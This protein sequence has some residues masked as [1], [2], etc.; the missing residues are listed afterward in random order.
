MTSF[1]ISRVPFSPESL[2]TWAGLDGRNTNWPVVYVLDGAAA[3]NTPK[4]NIRLRDVYVGESLNAAARMRQHLASAGKSHLTSARFIVDGKF[5][6]SVCLDL[7]SHLIRLLAGDGAFQVLNRNDGIVDADYYD[8]GDYRQTFQEVFDQLRRDGLFTRDIAEIENSDLFKLSPF[9]ALTHDQ[10]VAVVDIL[11]GLF[12]DLKSGETSTIVIQGEPGTGKTVVAIYILKLLADIADALPSEAPDRD[13]LFADFFMDGFKELLVDT[14]I[15]LVIPQQ[16]LRDSVRKVFQRTPGLRPEMV[17]TA[18]DVG[19][20]TEKFDLL[21][22]DEAHRLNQR[23]NQPSG[24]QNKNFRLITE[25]LFGFDDKTKTQLDWIRAQSKNQIFLLDTAQ[26]VRPADVSPEALDGLVTTSRETERYYPLTTQMRVQAGSDYVGYI[27]RVL[28]SVEGDFEPTKFEGYDLRMFDSVLEM[29]EEIHRRDSE[30]GLSRLVAGYAWPWKSK[31][32]KS[33]FDIDVQ[34]QHFR[35]NSVQTD[36]IASPNSLHEVGSI[37]TVQGYDLNFAGVIIGAD[38]RYDA[39]EGRLLIDRA[40][41]FDTKG[42]EN[43]PTLGRI[44][45][46]HDL[47]R[48]IANIYSVLMTR[49]VLGTYVYVVDPGLR[50]YL[51]PLVGAA[52]D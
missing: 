30:H 28:G 16:S 15:G 45:T 27:R 18:F 38:L 1:E 34:G 36:W 20:A 23:A 4:K 3:N 19:F 33:A 26:S 39:V 49:G 25:K 51:R 6:K 7:E 31:N 50:E 21:I 32:D 2:G 8:R 46:D 22:V 12:D 17:M 24:V 29:R 35:W 13:S 5:N 11:E 44:Y 43:N 42:K 47:L 48:Y 9:K 40:S 14:Q 37:H 41:Y 10:G 52:N